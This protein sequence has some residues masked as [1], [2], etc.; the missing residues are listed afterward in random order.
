MKYS[1]YGRNIFAKIVIYLLLAFAIGTTIAQF[2]Y[3]HH[4]PMLNILS[5]TSSVAMI[6]YWLGFQWHQNRNKD[7]K[8]VHQKLFVDEKNNPLH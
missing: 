7:E 8:D 6:L 3:K 5:N 2:I 4:P 1:L